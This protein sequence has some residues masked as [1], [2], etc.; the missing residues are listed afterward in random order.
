MKKLEHIEKQ[1]NLGIILAGMKKMVSK[2][3]IVNYQAQGQMGFKNT[4]GSN[5]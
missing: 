5:I 2:I 3:T 4:T 1:K